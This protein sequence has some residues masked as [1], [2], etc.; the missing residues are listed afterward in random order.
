MRCK[1][2]RILN[3]N[4][5][6]RTKNK[7]WK[8]S[9]IKKLKQEQSVDGA[10]AE[11]I[12]KIIEELTQPLQKTDNKEAQDSKNGIGNKIKDIFQ[13]ILEEFQELIAENED[14]NSFIGGLIKIFTILL[15]TKSS[16]INKLKKIIKISAETARM[17][18]T[19]ATVR[20]LPSFITAPGQRIENKNFL[21][22]RPRNAL[23]NSKSFYC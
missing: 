21:N 14:Q 23:S 1:Q 16:T 5:Q 3:K 10:K 11:I 19:K 9:K 7:R 20:R 13:P 22:R 15:R 8:K 6:E 17:A 2:L 4:V 12:N 18:R